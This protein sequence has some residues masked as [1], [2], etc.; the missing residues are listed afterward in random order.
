MILQNFLVKFTRATLGS[1]LAAALLTALQAAETAG[2]APQGY[3]RFPAIHGGTIVFTAEGDLWRVGVQG[4]MA[5]R[6][7]S[8]PGTESRASFSPDGKTLAFSA[9]YEGPTEIYTMPI[10]GGLP[11]RRTFEGRS[12][13]VVGWTP[14]GKLLYSTT[15]YSTLPN[16]Q[17]ATIDLQ[18]GEQ[19][20]LPLSQARDGVF[21]PSGKT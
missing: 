10:E 21:D 20:L 15:Q 1:V 18:T 12:A 4:G 7:T 8:H 11:T 16:W 9:E 5:Q 3:Y 19:A 17:L 6:L 14:N 2:G 13:A